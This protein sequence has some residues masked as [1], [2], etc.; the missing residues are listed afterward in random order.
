[1]DAPL[2]LPPPK[3]KRISFTESTELDDRPSSFANTS[4]SFNTFVLSGICAP[5]SHRLIRTN[6]SRPIVQSFLLIAPVND[7]L[8]LF[9]MEPEPAL[10]LET[11]TSIPASNVITDDEL[12]LMFELEIGLGPHR[13]SL[14]CVSKPRPIRHGARSG[15]SIPLGL[16]EYGR[17]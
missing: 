4:R 1:M 11:D 6:L 16:G 13:A 15:A 3:P 12:G 2:R 8:A 14:P 10:Q 5:I 7:E 17:R 9:S